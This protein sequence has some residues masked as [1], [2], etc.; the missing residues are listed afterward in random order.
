M[1]F[2]VMSSVVTVKRVF[3]VELFLEILIVGPVVSMELCD[4]LFGQHV[5]DIRK[6]HQAAIRP[7]RKVS[8]VGIGKL[9]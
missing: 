3:I 9:H 5:E 6:I 8:E 7:P 1:V 2:M 4:L